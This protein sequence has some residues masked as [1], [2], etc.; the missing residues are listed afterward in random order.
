MSKTMVERVR[1]FKLNYRDIKWISGKWFNGDKEITEINKK[2]L[3][4]GYV[5]N[6]TS[7]LKNFKQTFIQMW[8]EEGPWPQ[9]DI[10]TEA[11]K[12]IAEG[13]RVNKLAYPLND[14]ELKLINY[15]LVGKPEYAIFFYGVGGSGKTTICNIICQIFGRNNVY[16]SNLIDISRFNIGLMEARLFYDDDMGSQITDAQVSRLKPMVTN[17]ETK[18]EAKGVDPLQGNYRCKCLFCC[19]QPLRFDIQDEGMLRRIIYYSK[20]EKIINKDNSFY[21]KVYT[22]DELLDIVVAALSIDMTDWEQDFISET[23]SI[24]KMNNSVW[25]Y[26]MVSNYDTYV[27]NCDAA[28]VYPFNKDN[29]LKIKNIFKQW[30]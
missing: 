10:V 11:Q 23:H 20:N 8:G 5:T 12:L 6:G 15:L 29:W 3:Q 22:K 4:S 16:A 26:G 19:N 14:K 1:D 30:G 24:L 28:N 17:G 9:L 2:L 27:V 21:N 13:Y 7:D 18:F 25:L